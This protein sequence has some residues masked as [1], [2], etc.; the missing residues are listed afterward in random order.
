MV[1]VFALLDHSPPSL[2]ISATRICL[3]PLVTCRSSWHIFQRLPPYPYPLLLLRRNV[4]REAAVPQFLAHSLR[5]TFEAIRLG[6]LWVFLESLGYGT[7]IGKGDFSRFLFI[8]KALVRGAFQHFRASVEGISLYFLRGWRRNVDYIY[9][10][11]G[12]GSSSS[13]RIFLSPSRARRVMRMHAILSPQGA[14]EPVHM[15][16][17]ESWVVYTYWSAASQRTEMSTLSLYEGMIDKYGLGPFNR[18]SEC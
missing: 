3:Y 11:F 2:H 15:V 6:S 9:V 7:A 1:A 12:I 16:V 18:V 8:C 5:V 17:S 4:T 13:R 10:A 14:A